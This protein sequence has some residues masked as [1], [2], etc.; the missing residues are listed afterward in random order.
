MCSSVNTCHGGK[1]IESDCGK[2]LRGET[3]ILEQR[4]GKRGKKE[5]KCISI[6]YFA[7]LPIFLGAKAEARKK[8]LKFGTGI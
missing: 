2:I 7:S 6:R 4:M 8:V 3:Q 5:K 1:K